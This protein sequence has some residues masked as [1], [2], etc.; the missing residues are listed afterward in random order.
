MNIPHK[1]TPLSYKPHV[2]VCRTT[3]EQLLAELE[4]EGIDPAVHSAYWWVGRLSAQVEH[5]LAATAPE[6]EL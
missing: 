6:V 4:A 3:A 5:F 2:D 1:R